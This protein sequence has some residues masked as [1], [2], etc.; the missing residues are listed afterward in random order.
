MKEVL[1]DRSAAVSPMDPDLSSSE[2]VA[3]VVRRHVAADRLT[4]QALFK[5]TQYPHI[6]AVFV[7]GHINWQFF[8]D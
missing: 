1:T 4:S 2:L 7:T 3:V 5:G 8:T 6:T